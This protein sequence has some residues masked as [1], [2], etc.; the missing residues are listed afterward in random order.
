MIPAVKQKYQEK[1][2]ELQQELSVMRTTLS[3]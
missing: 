2:A 3:T 1:Y